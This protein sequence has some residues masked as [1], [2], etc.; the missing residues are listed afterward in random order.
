MSCTFPTKNSMEG[1]VFLLAS[2]CLSTVGTMSTI[3]VGWLPLATDYCACAELRSQSGRNKMAEV[4]LNV[5]GLLRVTS[6]LLCFVRSPAGRRR[7]H[8]EKKTGI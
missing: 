8:K 5:S 6:I 3:V 1:S 7:D 2:H 4:R